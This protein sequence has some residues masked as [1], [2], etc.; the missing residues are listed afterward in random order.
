MTLMNVAGLELSFG[1]RNIFSDVNF[2]I[3]EHDRIGLVGINGCG[4]TSLFKVLTGEYPA[5]T[6]NCAKSRLT[7]VGYV[8]QFAVSGDRSVYDELLTVFD[9]LKAIDKRINEINTTISNGEDNID[10]LIEELHRLTE[11]YA[12]RGGLTYKSRA[13]S[14][15]LGLG[16]TEEQLS[17]GINT[18]SGGQRSKVQLCKM[19]MSGAN[20]LLM[21]EPT[22]HLDISSVEW[23]EDFLRSFHGAYIVISH[24]RYF[25]DRV[26]NKTFELENSSLTAYG[27]NYSYYID[28][29][30]EN[31]EIAI[32]HFENTQ[33]EIKRIEGI[34]E[35]QRRWN[36]E[37][38]I[39]TAE[40]KLKQI[41]R[42][43]KTLVAVDR[44][45]ENFSFNFPVR[46][47]S[48]NDVLKGSDLAF[49]YGSR[50]IFH[51]VNIDIKK[52]ERVFLLGANGCG[53]TTL[54]KML[55][56]QLGGT[57]GYINLGSNVDIGYY[58]QTQESLHNGKTVLYEIWDEYPRMT[59]TE[60][61]SSLAAFL[62]KGDDVFK[63]IYDL[64]GGERARVA[65]LKL[66]LSQCNLLLLDEPTN[67]LDIISREALEMALTCYEGTIFMVSHDRYFI[68]RLADRIYYMEN[69]TV[70]EYIG[71]YDYLNAARAEKSVDNLQNVKS[72]STVGGEKLKRVNDYKQRKEEAAAERKRKKQIENA[73]NNIEKL[74][75]ELTELNERMTQPE[76]SSDYAKIMEMTNRA[77]E[78]QTQ[79][80]QLYTLLDEL[81]D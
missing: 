11:E 25:L 53:K 71:D 54:F 32:R 30:A 72:I 55:C 80:D 27:G 23:L 81:Y 41:E 46:N 43:K 4:K 21:D 49:A 18:L 13:R 42:L 64:S 34:V 50:E 74:E 3:D 17:Q 47:E 56:S 22:N 40:S 2:L 6:G 68:N 51:D 14:A 45:P 12:N 76:F 36:R 65:I 26:T 44:L 9:D 10:E 79:I 70:T 20:L 28:K 52:G 7:R 57:R 77:A 67:H 5:D 38:N 78:I 39:R 29:K 75:S 31:R 19:L 37:R 16:F 35:Q 63:N 59:E 61:R 33:R 66:M 24:D 60:V 73:E 48:G 15:L 8:E 58:D 62:F 1:A 69:N